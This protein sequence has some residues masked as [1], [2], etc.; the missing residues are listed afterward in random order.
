M[1]SKLKDRALAAYQRARAN[2]DRV[3]DRTFVQ[4]TLRL[5][6][7][8]A[9][10][11]T[12]ALGRVIRQQGPLVT[13]VSVAHA[14]VW[15]RHHVERAAHAIGSALGRSTNASL[16]EGYKAASNVLS[17]V[18][19]VASP[20]DSLAMQ[21][22]VVVMRE[23]ELARLREQSALGLG[24]DVHAV[25]W[26]RMQRAQVQGISVSELMGDIED[27]AD[28]QTWRVERLVRT[29]TSY[30]YNLA[31]ADAMQALTKED[32]FRGVMQRWTERVDDRTGRPLDNRVGRDSMQMH[33]QVVRP[34]GAFTAPDEWLVPGSW[35]HPPNRPNDR[36][37]L[38]PW[39]REWG[40]P[41]WM[42]QAGSRIEMGDFVRPSGQV[43]PGYP[44][45]RGS[46]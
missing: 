15:L 21:A 42:W 23:R 24:G 4:P 20:L 30:A 11:L 7:T 1:A 46:F 27:I 8:E 33:G 14:S 26:D 12:H 28:A 6:T 36:S 34:G 43:V 16:V 2:A 37:V 41:A 35:T 45:R 13:P 9:S 29:E 5:W 39:M 31:Q 25:L 3:I 19:G 32:G 22:R 44:G 18:R 40:V 10:K 38:T 17:F